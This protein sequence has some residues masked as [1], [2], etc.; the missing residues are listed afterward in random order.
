MSMMIMVE[1]KQHLWRC[2][3]QMAHQHSSS[4]SVAAAFAAD[5]WYRKPHYFQG[6][7]FFEDIL[8]LYHHHR[9]RDDENWRASSWVKTLYVSSQCFLSNNGLYYK[10]SG[11]NNTTLLSTWEEVLKKQSVG[12]VFM[13]FLFLYMKRCACD[14]RHLKWGQPKT[15]N[16]GTGRRKRLHSHFSCRSPKKDP[17][18][19]YSFA[20]ISQSPDVS[21]GYGSLLY[22]TGHITRGLILPN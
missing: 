11:A 21:F 10:K 2:Q 18:Y 14:Q 8:I 5:F 4:H 17:I 7:F 22:N 19:A 12:S 13:L 20:L 6:F 9:A 3:Y 16:M 1:Q 15:P